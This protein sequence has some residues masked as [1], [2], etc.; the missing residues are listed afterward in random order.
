MNPVNQIPVLIG[1]LGEAD[2]A[3]DTGI[4]DHHVHPVEIVQRQALTKVGANAAS[5]KTSKV[6][7]AVQF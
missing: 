6:W 7:R 1:H 4:V 5:C 2:V 3:Q